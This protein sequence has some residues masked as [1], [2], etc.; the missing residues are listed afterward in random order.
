MGA[1]LF[2][3]KPP[4]RIAIISL[5][6]V[7]KNDGRFS[8]QHAVKNLSYILDKNL[9]CLYNRCNGAKNTISCVPK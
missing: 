1:L 8:V 5:L 6:N 7:T 9:M 4:D 3:H 2:L